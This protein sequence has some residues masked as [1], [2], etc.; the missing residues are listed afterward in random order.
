MSAC[1][2]N[3]AM[4]QSSLTVNPVRQKRRVLVFWLH[5]H[6][7][8]P[9]RAEILCERQSHTGTFACVHRISRL[10]IVSLGVFYIRVLEFD[11]PMEN[12]GKTFKSNKL[13]YTDFSKLN[14]LRLEDSFCQ[15]RYR[16]LHRY[17]PQNC[18][19]PLA[20]AR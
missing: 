5:D 9:E 19:I 15:V 4:D 13:E 7:Q 2:S 8:T 3:R 10:H 14:R 12:K 18:Q 20:Y 17:I 1:W 11:K 16:N 6:T